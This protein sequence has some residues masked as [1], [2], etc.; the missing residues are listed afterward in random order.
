MLQ[1]PPASQNKIPVNILTEEWRRLNRG[2]GEHR[3]DTKNKYLTREQQ[4]TR[5]PLERKHG[6]GQ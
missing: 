6:A 1:N 2:D 4:M 3:N 5:N